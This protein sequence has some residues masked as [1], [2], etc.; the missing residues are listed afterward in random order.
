MKLPEDKKERQKI[1]L[2][3]GLGAAF[4]LYGTYAGVLTPL[5]HKKAEFQA[6][7]DAVGQELKKA[8][9]AI[10]Q[11]RADLALKA[12]AL[13]DIRSASEEHFL[14][15]RHGQQ[16]YF[17]DA[18]ERVEA[19][20]KRAGIALEADAVREESVSQIPQ[21]PGRKTDNLVKAY[22]VRVSFVGNYA[23][24]LRFLREA[25]TSNPYLSIVNVTISGRPPPDEDRHSAGVSIQWPVWDKPEAVAKFEAGAAEPA[26]APRKG[27]DM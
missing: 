13:R 25:E 15:P 6:K 9:R 5:L 14:K 3:I 27:G 11:I 2:A 1:F 7:K 17:F 16:N 12:E 21:A 24:I 23:E 8:E 20:A 10:G 26:S 18:T 22:S 19:L 4:V